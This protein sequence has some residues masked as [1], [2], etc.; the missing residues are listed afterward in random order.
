ME[1]INKYC[2]NWRE[3]Y[4]NKDFDGM[5]KEFNK[6]KDKMKEIVPIENTIKTARVIENLHSLIKNN[7]KNFELNEEELELAKVL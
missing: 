4:N 3:Y 5:E 2:N 6:I 1:K 7:G